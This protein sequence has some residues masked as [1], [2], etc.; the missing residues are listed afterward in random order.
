MTTASAPDEGMSEQRGQALSAL[1]LLLFA[2]CRTVRS[3]Y[4][5]GNDE[6]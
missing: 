4:K 3:E 6:T 5:D 2:L 1:L